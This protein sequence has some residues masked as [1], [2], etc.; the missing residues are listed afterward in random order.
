MKCV[1]CP[2]PAKWIFDDRGA[3]V[4]YFC[5]AHI[6]WFL[7]DR[8]KAGALKTVQAEVVEVQV[9]EVEEVTETPAPKKTRKKKG[10]SEQD[11]ESSD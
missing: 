11:S 1:N 5:E 3:A 6:P 8:A 9:E 4:Q 7:K 2:A 10:A